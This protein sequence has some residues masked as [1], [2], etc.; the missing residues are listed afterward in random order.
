VHTRSTAALTADDLRCA[1]HLG[2]PAAAVLVIP[3]VSV[4][5]AAN[6]LRS[7]IPGQVANRE[8]VTVHARQVLHDESSEDHIAGGIEVPTLQHDLAVAI[9]DE[10]AADR[11]EVPVSVEIDVD[12][13]EGV[14]PAFYSARQAAEFDSAF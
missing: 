9:V 14:I 10:D 7:A 11:I 6:H 2:L 8:C 5:R 13:R 12:N 3:H 1:S 4:R